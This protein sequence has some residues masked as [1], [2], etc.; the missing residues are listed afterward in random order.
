M[1]HLIRRFFG[2]IRARPLSPSE[3]ERVR[4]SLEPG[5]A[6]LFFSQA[7]QDQRH[8][9]DVLDRLG[10]SDPD[11]MEA[12]LLHDIGKAASRLGPISR[13]LATVA[14]FLHL[15][16]PSRWASYLD[17]GRIGA[18]ILS[19]AGASSFAVAFSLHH[20]G[21]A[22]EGIDSEVWALVEAADDA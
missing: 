17:H 6:R 14:A 22:P 12:A 21:A 4:R 9:I 5:L 2:Y 10:T 20:P 13:S 11:L 1:L 8:A 15:S 3:Q 7:H 16:V 19:D 18:E